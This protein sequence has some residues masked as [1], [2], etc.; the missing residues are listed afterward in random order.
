MRLSARTPPSWPPGKDRRWRP[1]EAPLGGRPLNPSIDSRPVGTVSL[2]PGP[3][4]GRLTVCWPDTGGRW[5]TASLVSGAF[6]GNRCERGGG[7]GVKDQSQPACPGSVSLA[8][9]GK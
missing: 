6:H 4:C 2:G 1:A 9:R 3:G 7:E 8:G 5:S